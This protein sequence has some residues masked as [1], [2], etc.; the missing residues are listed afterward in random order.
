[1]NNFEISIGYRENVVLTTV[2]RKIKSV[3]VFYE[4][5]GNT[6]I[7]SL[8]F[9]LEFKTF[10]AKQVNSFIDF[11][12]EKTLTAKHSIDDYVL[13]FTILQAIGYADS[14]AAQQIVNYFLKIDMTDYIDGC[15]TFNVRLLTELIKKMNPIQMRK[16]MKKRI[17]FVKMAENN[18]DI[19]NYI[20]KKIY[21]YDDKFDT[22]AR[23]YVRYYFNYFGEN[24]ICRLHYLCILSLY[25]VSRT[26]IVSLLDLQTYFLYD[27]APK[28]LDKG[29]PLNISVLKNF[30]IKNDLSVR[31]IFMTRHAAIFFNSWIIYYGLRH[32]NNYLV[33]F[34][35]KI[36]YVD[37][38]QDDFYILNKAIADKLINGHVDVI[39]KL[40]EHGFTFN[41]AIYVALL[42]S[43][44]SNED[45]MKI[46]ENNTNKKILKAQQL[47]HKKN[48]KLFNYY[49]GNENDVKVCHFDL[50]RT[51]EFAKYENYDYYNKHIHRLQPLIMDS[52]G[53]EMII[54]LIELDATDDEYVNYFKLLVNYKL[55]DPV[56]LNIFMCCKK[57]PSPK[58]FKDAEII[59]AVLTFVK[60]YFTDKKHMES[61]VRSIDLDFVNENKVFY[62]SRSDYHLMQLLFKY[63]ILSEK[64]DNRLKYMLDRKTKLKNSLEE[65]IKYVDD[66]GDF[67]YLVNF[68][69]A[70][71]DC[72]KTNFYSTFVDANKTL[73]RSVY[74]KFKF[75]SSLVNKTT[76]VENLNLPYFVK[77]YITRPVL[78]YNDLMFEIN[79]GFAIDPDYLEDIISRHIPKYNFL[80]HVVMEIACYYDFHVGVN[81]LKKFNPDDYH[82]DRFGCPVKIENSSHEP[83]T[84]IDFINQWMF[85]EHDEYFMDVSVGFRTVYPGSRKTP[86][87]DFA[88]P[89]YIYGE[90][91]A[92]D[93]VKFCEEPTQLKKDHLSDLQNHITDGRDKKILEQ[94]RDYYQKKSDYFKN[95]II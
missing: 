11:L 76:I 79:I 66:S 90:V 45:K 19:I 31:N 91:P 58:C 26:D 92:I 27:F 85:V 18:N 81:I 95:L 88:F 32:N 48:L 84:V 69:M 82:D 14:Q 94:L 89:Y 9:V 20:V 42:R 62:N 8:R 24:I 57:G 15:D 50:L 43:N 34:I 71:H 53:H 59:T 70:D 23:E 33:E 38:S 55:S 64:C 41:T 40:I 73:I 51:I 78:E 68:R 35:M 13:Y 54:H 4:K 77:N 3:Y 61:I 25:G 44:L 21:E 56:M 83:F 63:R 39:N 16:F 67:D 86:N 29:E 10:T 22:S 7:K 46:A 6:L 30:I 65:E 36:G 47:V 12:T 93:D 28:L 1:M 72:E 75:I 49:L 37:N 80:P 2:T 52:Y 60:N 87:I 74:K 17:I 5:S